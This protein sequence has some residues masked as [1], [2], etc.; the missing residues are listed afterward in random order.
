MSIPSENDNIPLKKSKKKIN[1]GRNPKLPKARHGRPPKEGYSQEECI[2]L[3]E[4]M[5][6][7]VKAKGPSVVH[8]SEWYVWEKDMSRTEFRQLR[9]RYHFKPY[10]EKALDII[11]TNILNHKD[12]PTAYGSRFLAIYFKD[13]KDQEWEF[14]KKKIDYEVEKKFAMEQAK[15]SP[16][17]DKVLDELVS[18]LKLKK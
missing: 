5:L 11:G 2:Q 18:E 1:R 13:V 16:P 8:L 3:G 6:E 17:N 10:Y 12:L 7:W 15:N 4:D 14:T 9:N